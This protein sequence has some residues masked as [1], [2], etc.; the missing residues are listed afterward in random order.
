MPHLMEEEEW[1]KAKSEARRGKPK[2]T[3]EG[4]IRIAINWCG[5]SG[6][7]MFDRRGNQLGDA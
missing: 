7:V 4:E 1:Y 5:C 6:E 2:D 3:L